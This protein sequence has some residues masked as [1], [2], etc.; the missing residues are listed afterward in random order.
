MPTLGFVKLVFQILRWLVLGILGVLAVLFLLLVSNNDAKP[1]GLSEEERAAMVVR[2]EYSE[3][4]DAA[5]FDELIEEFGNKKQLAPGFE[6][7][8]LLALSHF[9]EL[10][11]TPIDFVVGPVYWPLSS[12]PEILSTLLPWL[13]RKYLVF[14]SSGSDDHWEPILLKNTPF[15]EQ[16]AIIAHELGHSVY[17]Q[18]KT[19]LQLIKIGYRYEYDRDFYLEFER[20]GDEL[21]I[22]RGL[23]YQMYD[24]AWFVRKAF[25]NSQEKIES[26]Q[27]GGPYLN[28]KEIAREMEKYE[29][30][31]EPLPLGELYFAE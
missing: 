4:A 13:E 8:C 31:Q 17:Y 12:R 15:N 23:G 9:P 18:D 25:G 27:G 19:A 28:P 29:F 26:N 11:D 1:A 24:Y 5:R 6:L 21:A 22:E 7:Q 2:L 30:Y 16:V 3:A 10:R 14:I 20:F